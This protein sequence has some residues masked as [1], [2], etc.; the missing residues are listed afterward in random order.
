MEC[1]KDI[2]Q[3]N[4]DAYHAMM[5]NM[6]T[7]CRWVFRALIFVQHTYQIHASGIRSSTTAGPSVSICVDNMTTALI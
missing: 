2:K 5:A 6:Y 4:P 1:L 7:A 3:R